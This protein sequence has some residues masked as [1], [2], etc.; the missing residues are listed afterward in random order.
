[1]IEFNLIKIESIN[2]LNNEKINIK[3][4]INKM[5]NFK[6]VLIVI[7]III[8]VALCCTFWFKGFENKA[9]SYE[10]QISNA[11]S[12]IKV[13]EKRRADLIPNLVDCVKEY[14]KH[15]YQTLMDVINA[16][17]TSSDESVGEI[18]TMIQAVAEAYPELKSN[19]NYKELMNELSTTEN[20]IA[21]YRSNYNNWVK[22]YKQYVRHFPNSSILGFLGYEVAEYEYI[23]YNVS[24]DAPTNLFGND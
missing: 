21:N 22:K 7:G 10:E 2:I 19:E 11:Q 15:E 20:L 1:M 23:D 24:E 3:G 16:R 8:A 4:I 13:Q 18:Q 6:V 5:K 17:G 12:E 14:D 9:I